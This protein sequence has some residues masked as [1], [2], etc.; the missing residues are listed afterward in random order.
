MRSIKAHDRELEIWYHRV[1]NGEIKLPRFQR[2]EAWDRHRITS[3][4]NTILHNLPLGVTLIL[5]IDKEHF[6]SRHIETAPQPRDG[7]VIEHLLDGQQR[8][9]AIWRALHN[10]YPWEKYF[11]NFREY[12]KVWPKPEETDEEEMGAGVKV[13][14]QT[15]WKKKDGKTM[16]LGQMIQWNALI[17]GAS[18]LIC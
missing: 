17:V 1:K 13:Y 7:R 12:N 2:F 10:N 16:P 4:L 18:H 3:L 6:I 8:V 14:C 11:I 9:T 15:R 5:E